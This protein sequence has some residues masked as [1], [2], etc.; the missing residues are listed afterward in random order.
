MNDDDLCLVCGASWQCEHARP[1][2]HGLSGKRHDAERQ[3]PSGDAM[4]EA[5]PPGPG[6]AVELLERAAAM[7]RFAGNIASLSVQRGLSNH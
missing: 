1:G 4:T 5:T 7:E 2:A 6:D 3:A